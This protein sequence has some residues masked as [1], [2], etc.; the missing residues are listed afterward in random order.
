MVEYAIIQVNDQ[1][2]FIKS[3]HLD[4]KIALVTYSNANKQWVADFLTDVP[5]SA[6]AM[7]VIAKFV[8]KQNKIDSPEYALAT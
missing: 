4:R 5:Y 3:L 8:N 2:C 7:M 1:A 6:K